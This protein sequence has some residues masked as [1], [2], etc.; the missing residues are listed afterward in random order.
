MRPVQLSSSRNCIGRP[1]AERELS[2]SRS[3]WGEEGNL[4]WTKVYSPPRTSRLTSPLGQL[5]SARGKPHDIPKSLVV[6]RSTRERLGPCNQRGTA[7]HHRKLFTFFH[8]NHCGEHH[9]SEIRFV[10][11]REPRKR[12]QTET[13]R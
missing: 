2:R 4:Q 13:V 9:L 3:M 12:Q 7:S 5:A 1:G 8:A 10:F 6:G 11:A